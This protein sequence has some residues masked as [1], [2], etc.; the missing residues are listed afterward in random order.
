MSG[1]AEAR[2]HTEGAPAW[3]VILFRVAAFA[4]VVALDFVGDSGRR[5]VPRLTPSSIAWPA[6]AD[7]RRP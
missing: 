3:T 7:V 1:P 6:A 2:R 4:E 5:A